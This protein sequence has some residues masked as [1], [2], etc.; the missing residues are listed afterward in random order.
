MVK[1]PHANTGDTGSIPGLGGSPGEGNGKPLQYSCLENSMARGG[2]WATVRGVA[3]LDTSEPPSTQ[4]APL[5]RGPWSPLV[6]I[7]GSAVRFYLVCGGLEWPGPHALAFLSEMAAV[8]SHN[9]VQE[10]CLMSSADGPPCC[11]MTASKAAAQVV[12]LFPQL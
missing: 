2:W 4:Q 1:N 5:P 9:S 7:F 11:P 10:G 3:E 8:W 12:P 6:A